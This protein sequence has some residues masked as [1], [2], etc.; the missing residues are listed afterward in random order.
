MKHALEGLIY[1][2]SVGG[3]EILLFLNQNIPHYVS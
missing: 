3:L 2:L 1:P